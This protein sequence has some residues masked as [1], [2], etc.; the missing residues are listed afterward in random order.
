MTYTETLAALAILFFFFTAAGQI[1]TPLLKTIHTVKTAE[2]EQKNLIF[3][4]QSFRKACKHK[5]VDLHGWQYAV[6]AV[7]GLEKMKTSLRYEKGNVRVYQADIVFNG[8]P[9]SILTESE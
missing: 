1:G 3:I 9:I 2:Y 5:P 4:E 8:K 6:S 7:S